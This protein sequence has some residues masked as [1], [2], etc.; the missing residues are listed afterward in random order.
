MSQSYPSSLSS[1]INAIVVIVTVTVIVTVIIIAIVTVIVIVIVN[2]YLPIMEFV[3][4][5]RAWWMS[6][7]TSSHDSDCRILVFTIVNENTAHD[8]DCDCD[9]DCKDR[10]PV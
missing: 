7:L 6:Y 1:V 9:C 2:N 4:F 5:G 10:K 8:C 3:L